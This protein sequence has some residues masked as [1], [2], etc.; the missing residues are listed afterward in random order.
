MKVGVVGVGYIGVHHLRNLNRLMREG[1]VSYLYACDIDSSKRKLAERYDA[2]F[3]R[4]Y[5]LMISKDLDAVIL[6][7]PS[8]THYT[9]GMELINSGV[10]ILI[11]KPM[12]IKPDE[13]LEL[14]DAAKKQNILLM[15]GHVERYNPAIRSLYNDIREG[16][17]GDIIS[18]SSRRHGGPRKVDTGIILDIGI[19]DIDIMRY[20]AGKEVKK[21]YSYTINKLRDVD[22]EDYAVILMEFENGILG[23][24]EAGRL[25]S[26]KVRE[27]NIIGTKN[28]V[29]LD[30]MRQE[31]T[32]IENY[33]VG[34]GWKDYL[35]FI[36]K[37]TP[38]KKLIKVE[39]EEPL[40][41]EIKDFL[42]AIEKASK[43]PIDPYDGL[44]AVKIAYAALESS[45]MGRPMN[46]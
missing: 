32:V 45:K 22:S 13:C 9:L 24:V 39:G 25:T 23:T 17:V 12:C 15:P 19:H 1:Y 26:V 10:N 21:V 3:Y 46:I 6:A 36:K 7:T 42:E 29:S 35:D 34:G 20:L 4:D 33:L 28:Y 40:Y 8:K 30:Y 14:I 41:L 2:E 43:P 16:I 37:Y 5:R 18:M 31:Y 11:E 27:L 44:F 38:V